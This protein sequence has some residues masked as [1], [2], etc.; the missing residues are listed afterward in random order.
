MQNKPNFIN[1]LTEAMNHVA[2]AKDNK[3]INQLIEKL[4]MDFTD[5]ERATLLIF[6]KERML[7]F[8]DNGEKTQ[9]FSVVGSD[10]GLAGYTLNT[11]KS[12]IFNHVTSEKYYEASIDNPSNMRIKGQIIV[13]LIQE[14]KIYGLARVSR[15]ILFNRNY[16]KTQLDMIKSIE[17]FL[18]KIIN[19]MQ[20]GNKAQ[21]MDVNKQEVE[22]KITQA[23]KSSINDSEEINSTMLFLSNTVHDIRTPANSLYGFLD[24]MEEQIKDE[25]LLGFIA[26]AKESA[27]FINTLTDSILERIK[28]EKESST[29][30]PTVINTI[31]F[32]SNVANIFTA[33]MFKKEIH[34]LIYID[35]LIPKEIEIEE[36]KI[37]RVLINLIGN[38]YKF[39][40][41][42][43]VIEFRIE[44]N[45]L[46][47]SL[48]FSVKDT[49]IGIAKENQEKIFEAFEQAQADTSIH[50]GGTGL[51][52]AIS[53]KY[54]Q[55]LGGKLKLE[56]EID[57]GSNFY[58]AIPIRIIDESPAHLSFEDP[59]KFIT[60]LT[61]RPACIDANNMR[62]YLQDLS[63]ADENIAISQSIT[64][65]TTHLFCFEHKLSEEIV[66]ECKERNIKLVAI[67]EQLF[68][69]TKNPKYKNLKVISENSYY[70]DVLYSAV[71]SQRKPRIFIADDNKINVMLL[72]TI[73][74]S[75]YCTIEYALDGQDALNTLIKGLKTSRP[76]DAVFIDKHMPSLSGIEVI[77]QYKE[78]EAKYKQ[79][80][81]L[82]VIS[83]TGDPSIS[84]E[85]KRL[86]DLIVSKPFS[87]SEI[88]E[89]FTK[90]VTQ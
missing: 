26:N 48:T 16:T 58:F 89:A 82:K 53:A 61:D 56:S 86:Y 51:G 32:F 88:R 62:K 47:K 2:Q 10:I 30:E 28:Y 77:E 35:P 68:S 72:K 65:K 43:K 46:Q 12:A 36:L 29:S 74:E 69:I 44:Y 80:R 22:E 83:I 14:E 76:F 1:T 31:K 63:I 4:L 15:S 7:L 52:L 34:Y 19:I 21:S 71:S 78:Q 57:K 8:N 67:E 17:G 37:K 25:R 27:Q 40:P 84:N 75:E 45:A 18:I 23:K 3:E 60:I 24:L 20:G 39:T 9:K 54:V 41:K 81:P 64:P 50:F 55:D 87:K 38:A 42:D 59:T 79:I 85:E 6:D 11:K 33:N 73:L 13:P 5:S 70:G 90:S 66:K 49:G